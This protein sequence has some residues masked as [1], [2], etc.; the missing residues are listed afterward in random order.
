M[1]S[2]SSVVRARALMLKTTGLMD[3]R[4]AALDYPRQLGSPPKRRARW[5]L[6][7]SNR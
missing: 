6:E 7:I 5:V 4:I 2:A 3:L 1:V